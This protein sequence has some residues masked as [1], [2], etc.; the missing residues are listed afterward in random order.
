VVSDLASLLPQCD[1][2]SGVA[3]LGA[4]K[5]ALVVNAGELIR[6]ASGA[7]QSFA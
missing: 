4:G 6:A 5:L 2:L 7:G 3:Q 1:R